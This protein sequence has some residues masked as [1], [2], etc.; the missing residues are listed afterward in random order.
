MSILRVNEVDLND[1]GNA[2]VQIANSWNVALVSG[3]TIR[4]EARTDGSVIVP[5]NISATGQINTNNLVVTGQI[6][7]NNL[8][9]TGQVLESLSVNNLRIL[10]VTDFQDRHSI[11]A[12]A[13][14]NVINCIVSNYF[15][16]NV[17]ASETITFTNPP[18][19]GNAYGMVLE[20]ANGGAF[21]ITWAN[22]P[23]WPSATAP[24]LSGNV[25]NVD[26][27]VFTTRD[28]GTTWRGALVQKDSR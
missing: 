14:T 21:T 23:R 7:T 18:I 11:V 10:G 1:V 8:V 9:V 5:G 6:N 13:T 16:R 3:G 12:N 20:L 25:G 4:L 26:L 17:T 28:G 22:N 15:T 19:T 2:S 27:L 24:T